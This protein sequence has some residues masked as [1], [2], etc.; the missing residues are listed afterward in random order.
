[1]RCEHRV[2]RFDPAVTADPALVLSCFSFPPT[3]GRRSA[4]QL[5]RQ[6]VSSH[7]LSEG[8]SRHRKTLMMECSPLVLPIWDGP[9]CCVSHG[10][11]HRGAETLCPCRSTGSA[12]CALLLFSSVLRIQIL[13]ETPAVTLPSQAPASLVFP[14][15]TKGA[16]PGQAFLL[17]FAD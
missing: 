2:P 8:N 4:G 13:Y 14:S 9:P 7:S 5:T 6:P 12:T 3:T 11:G 16:M 15:C 17:Y 1:M 10:Q